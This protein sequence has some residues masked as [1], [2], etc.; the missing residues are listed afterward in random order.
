MYKVSKWKRK[1]KI[2][3]RKI[4]LDKNK[5]YFSLTSNEHGQ[6]TTQIHHQRTIRSPYSYHNHHSS[7]TELCSHN[8]RLSFYTGNNARTS[9][10]ESLVVDL[11]SG[12]HSY[13]K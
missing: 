11:G 3:R 10:P 7:S 8:S 4:R 9:R 12:D 1:F 2:T 5:F 13:S 6:Y